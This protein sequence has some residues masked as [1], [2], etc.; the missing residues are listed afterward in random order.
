[1]SGTVNPI[2]PEIGVEVTGIHGHAFV[3]VDV[4]HQCEILLERHG[5]VV[6]RD[7]HIDDD[8]LIAFSRLLGQVEVRP[9]YADSG[10]PELF[11]VSLDSERSTAAPVQSGTFNWHIDGTTSEFPHKTTLL[12]CRKVSN[13]GSGDTEFANTYAAYAALSEDDKAALD[14]VL[15]EYGFANVAHREIQGLSDHA[16]EVFE[17]TPQKVRP[18][19]WARESGRRSMLLGSTAGDIVG[20][21]SEASRDL[22]DRML[23]W[24]TQPR[25]VVRH[26]WRLGDLVL[27][28]KTGLLQ[29]ALPYRKWS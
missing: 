4:A 19:V 13:D 8:D 18:V 20:R 10:R 27:W 17:N 23:A 26:R 12:A 7:A 6:Y 25:F 15:V 5:V 21:S 24:A 2:K 16:R 14:A 29:R 3:D 9:S 11:I 28:D 1:M 22:L